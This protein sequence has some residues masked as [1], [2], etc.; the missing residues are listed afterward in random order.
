MTIRCTSCCA[1]ATS[2]SSTGARRTDR[3]AICLIAIFAGSIFADSLTGDGLSNRL[4]G[5][6]GSDLLFGGGG[7]DNLLGGLANDSLYGGDGDDTL[8]G[9]GGADLLFGG[10]GTMDWASFAGSTAVTV[11]LDG[12][13][14]VGGDAQG[15]VLSGIENLLGSSNADFLKSF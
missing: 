15:D 1:T 12:T 8:I 13:P 9:G 6:L 14:E 4:E 10:N 7:G 11:T 5:G 2:P 3:P